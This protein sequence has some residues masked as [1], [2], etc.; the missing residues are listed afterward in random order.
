MSYAIFR[1]EPIYTL[2]DLAQIGSHNRREKKAYQSN[3]DI[4]ISK[5]QNNIEIIPCLSK[6]TK[7]FYQMTSDYKKEHEEKMLTMREDRKKSFS[8]ML[9]SSK[10]VVADEMIFTS[11]NIFFEQMDENDIK[12][13][14]NTC[15][16]FIYN[17]IGYSKEQILHATVHMDEKTPH[18]H[19]VVVPLVRKY[20]NRT[21][22]MRYAISK[23]QYI[24]DKY[25]LSELQDK[26]H[27]RMIE[28]GFDLRRGIK[29][30]D[31]EHLT[32]KEFKKIT[33]KLDN[34]ITAQNKKLKAEYDKLQDSLNSSKETFNKKEIK[35]SK[36]SYQ[37][38]KNL[39]ETTKQVLEETP[40]NLALSN[41]IN[42]Y[43]NSYHQLAM[44]KAEI[45]YEVDNLK[46]K[47]KDLRL[48]NKILTDLLFNVFQTLK[49]WFHKI[50][51]LGNE[52]DKKEIGKE[53]TD[54]QTKGYYNYNDIKD[55]VKNT[56][57]ENQFIK[58]ENYYELESTYSNKDKD[59]SFSL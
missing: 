50:L 37:Q 11:D 49:K 14:A 45:Q 35:I 1:T 15:M 16:E 43:I 17:D 34:N 56:S 38:I 55:I 33:R 44:E 40:R 12:K 42:G 46:K 19:C 28:N 7:K 9:N 39:A 47:N 30:S 41:S 53:I 22:T 24:K 58:E 59:D 31:N 4:D 51:C 54:Y 10:S 20:D 18:L 26:Y 29:H 48:K 27:K 2:K 36:E 32:V 8:Q 25:H 21:K 5:T 3:P 57:L 52:Q 6:Y 23:K 13:W